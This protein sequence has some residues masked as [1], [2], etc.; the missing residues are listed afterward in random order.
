[1]YIF[2]CVYITFSTRY[3][4]FQGYQTTRQKQV[5]DLQPTIPPQAVMYYSIWVSSIQI[6][7]IVSFSF[8]TQ[9]ALIDLALVGWKCSNPRHS[10]RWRKSSSTKRLSHWKSFQWNSY[11]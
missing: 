1:M 6:S 11:L 5:L 8:I 7:S 10:T 4:G 3:F 2:I 9:F